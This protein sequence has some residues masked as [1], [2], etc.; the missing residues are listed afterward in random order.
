MSVQEKISNEQQD[1]SALRQQEFAASERARLASTRVPLDPSVA[2]LTAEDR[3]R[4]PAPQPVRVREE[5]GSE[6][7]PFGVAEQQLAWPEIPGFRLYWFN[8]VP[9]RIERAK[10]AGYDHV[11]DQDGTAVS[12]IVGINPQ[13]P[14]GLKSYLMKM[15]IEWYEQDR[16]KTEELEQRTMQ[17]IQSGNLQNAA[18]QNG[19]MPTGRTKIT[20]SQRR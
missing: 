11:N 1:A 16:A 6:R 7:K 12:R 14:G 2:A 20:A 8:D 19:Y 4:A 17:Q 18:V 9:G 10:R 15:P 3:A 13:A 5:F